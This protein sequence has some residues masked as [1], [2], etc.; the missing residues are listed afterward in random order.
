MRA[1][2]NDAI[3][4]SINGTIDELQPLEGDL[5]RIVV[6]GSKGFVL[7]ATGPVG[8]ADRV[9]RTNHGGRRFQENQRFFGELFLHLRGVV[10]VVQPDAHHDR[11]LHRRKE[12]ERRARG[13]LVAGLVAAEH[14]AA[15][16]EQVAIALERVAPAHPL[17]HSINA[18]HAGP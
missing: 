9:V 8:Q 6:Y 10:L 5:L 14:I 17:L 2:N 3:V 12:L 18:V 11:R 13:D 16:P 15:Q 4:V 7:D 1:P